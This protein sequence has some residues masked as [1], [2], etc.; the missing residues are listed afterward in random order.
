MH[1]LFNETITKGVFPDNLRLAEVTAVSKKDDPSDK[2]NYG[3]VTALPAIT[4]TYK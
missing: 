1:R 3:P 2:K 4:K